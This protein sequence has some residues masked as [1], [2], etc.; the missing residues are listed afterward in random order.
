MSRPDSTLEI[1]DD[2]DEDTVFNEHEWIAVGKTYPNNN[3]PHFI[4]KARNFAFSITIGDRSKI[5]RDPSLSI[6]NFYTV[7]T[8]RTGQNSGVSQTRSLVLL[9]NPQLKSQYSYEPPYSM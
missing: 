8:T 7:E 3:T 4:E 9:G 6:S 1:Q 2:D 5:L